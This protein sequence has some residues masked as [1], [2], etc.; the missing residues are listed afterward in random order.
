MEE[1]DRTIYLIFVKASGQLTAIPKSRSP[2]R[3]KPGDFLAASREYL[4]RARAEQAWR[5]QG[6][7]GPGVPASAPKSEETGNPYQPPRA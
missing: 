6:A 3:W 5:G 1:D 7:S 4:D 2:T